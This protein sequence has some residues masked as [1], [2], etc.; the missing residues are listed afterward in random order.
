[1]EDEL[2]KA[3]AISDQMF[4]THKERDLDF[5]WHKEKVDQLAERWQN[6]HCQIE[7]R[8]VLYICLFDYM[9]LLVGNIAQIYTHILAPIHKKNSVS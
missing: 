4:K 8:Y 3:K 5:D 6:I 1:M 2:Q 7:N 9:L